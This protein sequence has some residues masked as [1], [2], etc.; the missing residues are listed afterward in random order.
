[1]RRREEENSSSPSMG[2]G[3]VGV[4]AVA[5]WKRA[6][7]CIASIASPDAVSKHPHPSLPP[8]MGKEGFGSASALPDQLK[9]WDHQPAPAPAPASGKE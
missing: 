4:R 9:G 5:L 3:W 7:G 1:M 2:E 8:S 6:R